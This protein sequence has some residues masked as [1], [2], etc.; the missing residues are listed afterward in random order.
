VRYKGTSTANTSDSIKSPMVIE[1]LGSNIRHNTWVAVNTLGYSQERRC[2][3]GE[4]IQVDSL[5]TV[6]IFKLAYI[7]MGHCLVVCTNGLSTLG[8]CTMVC[9]HSQWHYSLIRGV[10]SCSMITSHLSIAPYCAIM[11][12]S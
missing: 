3:K 12:S 4:K 1:R 8:P 2:R 9:A 5:R 6:S 11:T 10:D 7:L